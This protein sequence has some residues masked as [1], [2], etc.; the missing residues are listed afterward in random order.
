MKLIGAANSAGSLSRRE[1]VGMRG[2]ALSMGSNPSPG[3]LP[4]ADLSL[5]ER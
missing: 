5:W 4:R 3:A 2:Y 1:R